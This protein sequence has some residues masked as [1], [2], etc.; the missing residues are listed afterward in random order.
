MHRSA[1]A[2]VPAR[3]Q[4]TAPAF[5]RRNGEL[6]RSL[7]ALIV[8]TVVGARDRA[9]RRS[10]RRLMHGLWRIDGEPLVDAPAPLPPTKRSATFDSSGWLH[11]LRV[12][13]ITHEH[14]RHAR[15]GFHP[16]QRELLTHKSLSAPGRDT[17]PI[18]RSWR[19]TVPRSA[20]FA[21]TGLVHSKYHQCWSPGFCYGPAHR[22]HDR[23]RTNE[24]LTTRPELAPICSLTR[25][26][27]ASRPGDSAG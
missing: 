17:V 24:Q 4:S 2:G 11:P 26:Q 7:F 5:A 25:I 1:A 6:C 12:E 8:M 15:G 20:P 27:S 16:R 21:K 13:R 9:S 14:W 19:T 10:R 3:L 22:P 18:S 23:A